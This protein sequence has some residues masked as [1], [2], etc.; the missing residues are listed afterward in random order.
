MWE[1]WTTAF[2]VQ[3]LSINRSQTTD[4]DK[5]TRLNNAARVQEQLFSETPQT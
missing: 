3:Q 4:S 2:Y 1:K 5:I